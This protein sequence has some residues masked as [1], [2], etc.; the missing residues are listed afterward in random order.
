MLANV[1]GI[2]RLKTT[3]LSL[4]QED[5]DNCRGK[6]LQRNFSTN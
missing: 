2:M 1:D 3:C 5:H 4:A 6:M